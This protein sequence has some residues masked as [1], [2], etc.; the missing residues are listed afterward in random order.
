MA[1]V[2]ESLL[3]PPEGIERLNRMFEAYCRGN[4]ELLRTHLETFIGDSEAIPASVFPQ[5][6]C[7]VFIK[8]ENLLL[9]IKEVLNRDTDKPDTPGNV[10]VTDE[11]VE[12]AVR[13]MAWE[14]S[15]IPAEDQP[16]LMREVLEKVLSNKVQ[17]AILL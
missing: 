13:S 2:T 1:D 15:T 5:R 17:E 4:L 14:G 6:F 16:S 3:M 12:T 7:G 9:D 11:M 10:V 8:S